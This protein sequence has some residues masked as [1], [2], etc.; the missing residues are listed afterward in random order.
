MRY[1]LLQHDDG[2]SAQLTRLLTEFRNSFLVSTLP[3]HRDLVSSDIDL[4]RPHHIM[5]TIRV[6]AIKKFDLTVL[7]VRGPRRSFTLDFAA[8]S[9]EDAKHKQ[10]EYQQPGC[11][12]VVFP[13]IM[14]AVWSKTAL[15][16]DFWPARPTKP[17]LVSPSTMVPFLPSS[18]PSA[19]FRLSVSPPEPT[20]T[21]MCRDF[22]A[23]IS[24]PVSFFMLNSRAARAPSRASFTLAGG[25]S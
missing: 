12:F 5:G 14:Q 1:C 13:A 17:F 10:N 2:I 22:W 24:L 20:N 9:G 21:P 8:H 15:V 18:S 7:F 25:A 23:E 16:Q 6:F 3:A 11:H 4:D 19:S